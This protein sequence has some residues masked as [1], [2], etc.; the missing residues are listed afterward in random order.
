[1]VRSIIG[2]IVGYIVMVG[3]QVAAFMKIYDLMGPDWSFKSASFQ[4]STRWHLMQFVVILLTAA[5]AGLVCALIAKRGKACLALAGLVMVIGMGLGILSHSGRPA[6][7]RPPGP[8]PG[9]EAMTKATHPLWLVFV[10]PF[11]AGVGVLAGG[12]LKRSR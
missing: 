9:R 1:M 5:I 4:A 2:V 6:D 10:M 12:S 11:I 8:I 7:T 3:L